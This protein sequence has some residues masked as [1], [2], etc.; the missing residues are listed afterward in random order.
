MYTM[1]QVLRYVRECSRDH[2]GVQ[3][4]AAF[5][6]QLEA[7]GS[8]RNLD[9]ASLPF[10]FA[11]SQQPQRPQ[12]PAAAGISSPGDGLQQASPAG[13]ISSLEGLLALHTPGRKRLKSLEDNGSLVHFAA[14]AAGPDDNKPY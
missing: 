11:G 4:L 3:S 8:G 6:L 14:A 12:P 7:E 1:H 2:V 13:A 10:T 9:V 5:I